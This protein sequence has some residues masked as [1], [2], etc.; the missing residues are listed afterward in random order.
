MS[1]KN[2]DDLEMDLNKLKEKQARLKEELIQRRKA[3]NIKAKKDRTRKLCNLAEIVTN[4]I[5]EDILDN[6]DPFELFILDHLVELKQYYG[7][8][9][10]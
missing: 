7:K 2:V 9:I 5:G 10:G 4:K 1:R 3:E 8:E 6:P